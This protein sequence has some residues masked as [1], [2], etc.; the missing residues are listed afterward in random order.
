MLDVIRIGCSRH[1]VWVGIASA[2]FCDYF[3]AFDTA[4]CLLLS[5]NYLGANAGL[6]SLKRTIVASPVETQEAP[7]ST[8]ASTIIA[9]CCA[10]CSYR[11]PPLRFFARLLAQICGSCSRKSLTSNHQN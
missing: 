8:F 4:A 6:R 9:T 11:C 5:R 1:V 3:V 2:A 10:D 7:V